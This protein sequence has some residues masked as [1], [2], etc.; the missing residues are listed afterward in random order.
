MPYF[1]RDSERE[2]R[3]QGCGDWFIP[4][5]RSCLVKHS[6]GTCCHEYERRVASP[7]TLPDLQET[8]GVERDD[9]NRR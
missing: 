6:P 3:C 7:A 2:Y 4:G 1:P 9:V 5:T 8:L